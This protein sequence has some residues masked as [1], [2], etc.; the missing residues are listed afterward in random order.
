[1]KIHEKREN[2]PRE[3]ADTGISLDE[4]DMKRLKKDGCAEVWYSYR[5]GYYCGAG[6]LVAMNANG[7]FHLHE[8]SHCSCYDALDDFNPKWTDASEVWANNPALKDDFRHLVEHYGFL[9][10]KLGIPE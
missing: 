5:I 7:D 1:M 6:E 4:Q 10:E 9:S 3:G 8:M 2:R